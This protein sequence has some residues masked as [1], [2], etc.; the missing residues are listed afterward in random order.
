MLFRQISDSRWQRRSAE[1][2]DAVKPA[3]HK[4][5]PLAT[6]RCTDLLTLVNFRFNLMDELLSINR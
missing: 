5:K 6:V 1:A 4:P 2:A 3:A